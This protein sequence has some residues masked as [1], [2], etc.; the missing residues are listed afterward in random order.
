[1]FARS[2][3]PCLRSSKFSSFLDC[4]NLAASGEQPLIFLYP[5][6]LYGGHYFR[7]AV[8]SS[9]HRFKVSATTGGRLPVWADS[10]RDSFG[11]IPESSRLLPRRSTHSQKGSCQNRDVN[12]ERRMLPAQHLRNPE[13]NRTSS[14]RSSTDGLQAASRI[15]SNTQS[16][17]VVGQQQELADVGPPESPNDLQL[18]DDYEEDLEDFMHEYTDGYKTDLSHLSV[19][20]QTPQDD[21][22][23]DQWGVDTRPINNPFRS[24]HQ[25]LMEKW[26]M[27]THRTS[28]DILDS[29]AYTKQTR[30]VQDDKE[31]DKQDLLEF[32]DVIQNELVKDYARSK[33]RWASQPIIKPPASRLARTTKSPPSNPEAPL[34]VVRETRLPG[35]IRISFTIPAFDEIKLDDS[36]PDKSASQQDDIIAPIR[37]L[38]DIPRSPFQGA[39][40]RSTFSSTVT[41]DIALCEQGLSES[42][43]TGSMTPSPAQDR[44]S[45]KSLRHDATPFRRANQ[46]DATLFKSLSDVK[47]NTEEKR[48]EDLIESVYLDTLLSNQEESFYRARKPQHEI[49]HSPEQLQ[50]TC[51]TS[52]VNLRQRTGPE[53]AENM[54]SVDKLPDQPRNS[55]VEWPGTVPDL[56]S[57]IEGI[58]GTHSEQSISSTLAYDFE[59][60]ERPVV[61]RKFANALNTRPPRKK[62]SARR[63]KAEIEGYLRGKM[64]IAQTLRIK[65]LTARE[66]K[67]ILYHLH[68]ASRG[69]HPLVRAT[70]ILY[71]LED[72]QKHGSLLSLQMKTK[73]LYL[74]DVMVAAIAGVAT[75]RENI[76]YLDVHNGCRI[77]VADVRQ[78]HGSSRKI[79]LSGSQ[80][81]IDLVEGRLFQLR[82]LRFSGNIPT[83][84]S[85][86][87]LKSQSQRA[88]D[89]TIRYV[90]SHRRSPRRLNLDEMD[91]SIEK[92]MK[93]VQD[94]T[95]TYYERWP[96]TP[97]STA[98]ERKKEAELEL[99]WLFST[100]EN[101]KHF[102]SAALNVALSFLCEQELLSTARFILSRAEAVVSVESYNILLRCAA[103]RGGDLWFFS[104]I[105]R[106]MSRLRMKPNDNTWIA[107]LE[108]LTMP[109]VRAT[110]LQKVIKKRYLSSEF[111]VEDAVQKHLGTM[112]A[113]HL[114]D[115]KNASSFIES[116]QSQHSFPILSAYS[117]N[118]LLERATAKGNFQAMVDILGYFR[119]HQLS[120]SSRTLNH[121][122]DFYQDDIQKALQFLFTHVPV[123]SYPF[124]SG[125]Y[126]KLFLIAWENQSYNVC[127]VLWRYACLEGST[128]PQMNLKLKSS[129]LY[130][131]DPSSRWL[132]TAGPCIIGLE[133]IAGLDN[134]PGYPER[135]LPP[136]YQEHPFLYLMDREA[137]R[138]SFQQKNAFAQAVLD[139]DIKAGPLNVPRI[140]L[141]LML[142]AAATIDR[143]LAK[144]V[145]QSD[146]KLFNDLI[147]IPLWKRR[148]DVFSYARSRSRLML[149]RELEGR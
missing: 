4:V 119:N 106:S 28:W 102:S 56:P 141:E 19:P 38:Q 40:R 123:A 148:K 29:A 65:H 72:L 116:M 103:A 99:M 131:D 143:E 77:H 55:F 13:R 45:I 85:L 22:W 8:I 61:L 97:G 114:D 107:F 92:F 53:V 58:Q 59:S 79:T 104:I 39:A 18:R 14:Y 115:D 17:R 80:Q 60:T 113:T 6:W 69:K 117:L 1:M 81:V 128:T 47:G 12:S 50:D 100:E 9:G 74:P 48:E 76:W 105:L 25:P 111:S 30:S 7:G 15:R 64:R 32:L 96:S 33:S 66:Q 144:H 31:E 110:V 134:P 78:S 109:E 147:C 41:Q 90:W 2:G 98:M 127:R 89:P 133:W 112:F 120:I 26:H 122:I 37:A 142:D 94:V 82:D 34:R 137:H 70:T 54:D 67:K 84:V 62:H 43:N 51:G 68:L 136:E 16:P 20:A 73:E 145:P 126:E 52:D 36:K 138:S 11:S 129:L 63:E 121:V 46:R 5:R 135:Q 95:N 87:V 83:P 44:W 118:I 140:R 3:G 146:S 139:R 88:N 42:R 130:H 35:G 71:M 124:D 101:I 27:M 108:A 10:Q 57:S 132:R 24:H 91:D 75:D 125:N 149:S 23:L 49:V 93:E 21:S 86:S